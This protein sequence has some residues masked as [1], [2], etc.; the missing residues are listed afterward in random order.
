MWFPQPQFRWKRVFL[1][2]LDWSCD[3]IGKVD[4]IHSNLTLY[5]V[6]LHLCNVVSNRLWRCAN[7]T[8]MPRLV[9]GM[10]I[11]HDLMH[12]RSLDFEFWIGR[13]AK[14]QI[15]QWRHQKFLKRGTFYGRKNERSKAGRLIWLITWIYYRGRTKAAS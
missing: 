2:K 7:N 13:R 14:L 11:A 10:H 6:A 5:S 15:M 1:S 8:K 4:N 3:V 12:R 9:S